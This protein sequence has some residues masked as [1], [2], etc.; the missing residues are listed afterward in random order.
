[1]KGSISVIIP[2]Y[3]RKEELIRAIESTRGQT[4]QPVEVIVVDDCSPFAV[5][6]FL[7]EVGLLTHAPVRVMRNQVNQGPSGS[8]NAGIWNAEGDFIAF[9]DSDDYWDERK[10]EKQMQ[11]F[12]HNPDL[13]LVYN[14][15]WLV[16]ED[17]TIPSG[18]ELFRDDIWHQL[19]DNCWTPPNPSTILARK[20]ILQDI[21]A[22]D[23]N[24][25]H[26]E[27]IDLWMRLIMNNVKIDYCDENLTYFTFDATGRLTKQYHDKF[28]RVKPFFAK[29]ENY[30]RDRGDRQAFD[31]FKSK[32]RTK[33]AIETFVDSLRDHVWDV[34]VKM[35]FKHLWNSRDFYELVFRK[36]SRT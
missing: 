3:N 6:D 34:P 24:L 19:V 16:Y 36:L 32:S 10:L 31:R 5:E 25:K 12:E 28:E 18:K 14:N 35:Y 7:E 8:R 27:D 17:K 22:F 1:M 29:W 9:L 13:G 21:Q 11:L 33:F 4:L 15:T 30:F 2:V 20:E 26:A 23:V